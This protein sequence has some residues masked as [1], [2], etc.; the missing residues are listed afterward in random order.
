MKKRVLLLLALTLIFTISA[1]ADVW[2][3][4]A[5]MPT[6]R[7]SLTSSSVDGKIY[8]IGGGRVVFSISSLQMRNT[9]LKQTHGRLRPRCLRHETG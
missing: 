1:H 7:I 5:P 8:V 3:A 4:K 9:I 2:T 6:P